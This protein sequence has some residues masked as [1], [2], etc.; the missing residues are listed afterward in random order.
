VNTPNGEIIRG[1]VSIFRG[2]A[3]GLSYLSS[4]SANGILRTG[5][6]WAEAVAVTANDA[7]QMIE[8]LKTLGHFMWRYVVAIEV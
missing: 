7:R 8:G 1:E 6:S 4:C 2:G 3:G 5:A